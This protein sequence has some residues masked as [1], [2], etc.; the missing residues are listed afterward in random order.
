MAACRLGA[1]SKVEV[2]RRDCRMEG[3]EASVEPSSCADG[4]KGRNDTISR[5]LRKLFFITTEG[6]PVNVFEG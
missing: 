6:F 3:T 5:K 2:N 1:E 4:S